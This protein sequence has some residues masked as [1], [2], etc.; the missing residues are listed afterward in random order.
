[1][2]EVEITNLSNP[3]LHE[4]ILNK[5]TRNAAREK[6]EKQSS[7]QKQNPKCKVQNRRD[8]KVPRV[9]FRA[10]SSK[11]VCFNGKSSSEMSIAK[12]TLVPNML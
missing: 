5:S 7:A 1:M 11:A 6:D 9:D 3:N 2:P 4:E 10:F 12:P 8:H